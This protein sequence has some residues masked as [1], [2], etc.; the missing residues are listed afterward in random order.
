MSHEAL[1]ERLLAQRKELITRLDAIEAD[2]RHEHDPLEQDSAERSVQ[3]ENDEVLTALDDEG[4]VVLRQIEQ[5]LKLMD[6]GSYG[7]CVECGLEIPLGRLE[8]V[9]YTIHC[10][11]CAEDLAKMQ[12]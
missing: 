5:A 10:V 12:S 7:V 4:V 1:R 3:M 8:A 2:A 11:D 9:P 6:E